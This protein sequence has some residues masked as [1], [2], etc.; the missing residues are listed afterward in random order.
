M[1][2]TVARTPRSGTLRAEGVGDSEEEDAHPAPTCFGSG[3]FI[4]RE[5]PQ[6]SHEG[7][8]GSEEAQ[9]IVARI[10]KIN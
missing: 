3:R 4:R 6:Q 7:G 10:D 9:V 1:G 5:Q 2:T 8:S